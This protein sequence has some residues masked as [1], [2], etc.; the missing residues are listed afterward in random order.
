MEAEFFVE[1]E[2]DGVALVGVGDEGLIAEAPGGVDVAEAQGGG[3][4]L[5][6][7]GG[8]DAGPVLEGL[9]GVAF[10]V[11]EGAEADE[12]V[13]G[14]GDEEA[15]GHDA[16]AVEALEEVLKGEGGE[17][18]VLD[19]VVELVEAS[20]DVGGALAFF[21]EAGDEGAARGDFVEEG[22]Q[23]REVGFGEGEAEFSG[24]AGL[25]EAALLHEADEFVVLLVFAHPE[26]GGFAGGGVVYEAGIEGAPGAAA[27]V[28][29][30]DDEEEAEPLRWVGGLLFEGAVTDDAL[31]GGVEDDVVP[32]KDLLFIDL[33]ALAEPALVAF[34]V[35]GDGGMSDGQDGL[36]IPVEKWADFKRH[37]RASLWGDRGRRRVGLGNRPTD[38]RG[39][40][41]GCQA[42]AGRVR[43]NLSAEGVAL[44]VTFEDDSPFP[45]LTR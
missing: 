5:A 22:G 38:N 30:G 13:I 25:D 37:A 7:V 40:V 44:C 1:G 45:L 27:K 19:G 17:G 9:L 14:S 36:A 3:D 43:C 28:A 2:Q 24:E 33:L 26:A 15:L 41:E 4:V 12:A 10:E 31:G 23:V 6:A 35:V 16:G 11:G 32:P 18:V 21:V 29:G 20:G 8:E 39:N 34:G 42:Q